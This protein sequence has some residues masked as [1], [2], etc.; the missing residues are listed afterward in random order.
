MSTDATLQSYQP[1]SESREGSWNDSHPDSVLDIPMH[2]L[3]VDDGEADMIQSIKTISRAMKTLLDESPIDNGAFDAAAGV[4]W[5]EGPP[6]SSCIRIEM[7]EETDSHNDEYIDEYD[8]FDYDDDDQHCETLLKK[9]KHDCNWWRN[10]KV[11]L[12]I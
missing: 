8:D 12:H 10:L 5:K 4:F 2:R 6:D 11:L 3:W 7:V 1:E 9:D